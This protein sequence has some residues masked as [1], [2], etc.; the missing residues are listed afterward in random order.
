MYLVVPVM[1]IH[2]ELCNANA[3]S[4]V[5]DVLFCM[6]RTICGCPPLRFKDVRRLFNTRTVTGSFRKYIMR[7]GR[8]VCCSSTV[9]VIVLSSSSGREGVTD[10]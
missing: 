8:G 10:V 6:F 7:Q 5:V 3:M 1:S 2:R 4:V 9:V